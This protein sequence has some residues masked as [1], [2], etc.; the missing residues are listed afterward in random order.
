[1]DQNTY[2]NNPSQRSN[3]KKSLMQEARETLGQYEN[4]FESSQQNTKRQKK[5]SKRTG[6]ILQDQA[7]KNGRRD[8]YQSE[9]SQ[10]SIA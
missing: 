8:S 10:D 1:M 3:K 7:N 6:Q 5:S 2:N 4:D 9:E